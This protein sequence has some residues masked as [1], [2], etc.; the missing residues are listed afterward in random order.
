[1]IVDVHCHIGFS[2]KPV[3]GDG[4]RFEFERRGNS[5]D[6]DLDSFMSPRLLS[7]PVWRILGHLMG[8]D[9]HL[10]PGADLDAAID[11]INRQ[12][13]DG[14]KS[15]DRLVL[16]AFD[17][18]HDDQG[19]P[20]GPADRGQR[21]GSDLYVSNSL[22]RAMCA[23]RPDRYLFGGSIH[24]YRVQDGVSAC[25]MLETLSAAGLAL[26]K[27]LPVHQN[28]RADDPRTVQFLRTAARLNVP[29]LIHYGGEMTL[30]RQH[31][32]FEDPEPML[33]VLG[34]L[35]QQGIM[36][37]VI[38]AHAATPSFVLQSAAG[39]RKLTEA[40]LGEFADAPLYADISALAACGR[41]G[42]L[43]RLAH[44]KAL[45]RKLVWGTD[46]PI[47]I[48]LH[49]FRWML[50]ASRYRALRA[51]PSWIERDLLLKRALGFDECVFTQA[52]EILKVG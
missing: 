29:L 52:G 36:P 9:T 41:T 17:R 38:V 10:L 19:Q 5:G 23:A 16:L 30:A 33:A 40:L 1:M 49:A 8:I 45:H 14:A 27:W 24:P 22:I 44:H 12:H 32:E 2:A 37:T 11:R 31:P 26:I 46:Y 28:I 39:Y 21:T 25:Q 34:R 20:L 47:P 7:R 3:D 42:W 15:V 13:F 43:K 50:G 48:M 18:Y 35:R 51:V 4:P 6:A